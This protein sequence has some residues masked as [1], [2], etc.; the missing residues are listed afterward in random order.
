MLAVRERIE[1]SM[2]HA[3][4]R[5][6]AR[7]GKKSIDCRLR[8]K[9]DI[10]DW[11][12][13]FASFLGLISNSSPLGNLGAFLFLA[14]F[15]LLALTRWLA[16]LKIAMQNIWVL[17]LPLLI[18]SSA[19]WS[20]YPDKTLRGGVQ[21]L[22]TVAAGVIA[23]AC[24]RPRV[25]ISASFCAFL[26]ATAVFLAFG[27][28]S[29]LSGSKNQVA[30]LG[31]Y[32]LLTALAIVLDPF[33]AR[34]LRVLAAGGAIAA[35]LTVHTAQSATTSVLVIPAAFTMFA[36]KALSFLPGH[37]RAAIATVIVAAALTSGLAGLSL[38]KS[39]SQVFEALGKD[40]R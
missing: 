13:T 37:A 38:L 20:D 39:E 5:S 19:F 4:V 24:M 21:F 12:L 16:L 29:I 8:D 23:G 28:L 30:M 6:G 40:L 26:C 2:V 1:G 33:Q 32:S 14:A 11:L 34:A 35:V 25:L 9:R 27:D 17:I 7:F 18:L 15:L 22:I 31:V 3:A 10:Q 36:L